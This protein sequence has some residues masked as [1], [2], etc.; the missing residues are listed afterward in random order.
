MLGE[1]F[2]IEFKNFF[3]INV[4]IPLCKGVLG[5]EGGKEKGEKGG[6]RLMG[7]FVRDLV[8]IMRETIGIFFWGD[9]ADFV[10]IISYPLVVVV[11]VVVGGD[12]EY[13]FEVKKKKRKKRKEEQKR[14]QKRE[15][16]T[17]TA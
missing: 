11:I 2:D 10:L 5:G 4:F 8:K 9:C 13:W 12:C 17:L 6:R 15:E 1:D 16:K 3:E 7:E 14:G